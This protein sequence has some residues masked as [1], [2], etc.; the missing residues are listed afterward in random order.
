MKKRLSKKSFLKHIASGGHVPT[1]A[2]PIEQKSAFESPSGMRTHF[3]AMVRNL[4][5]E[6]QETRR[7]R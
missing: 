5:G 6:V 3:F 7:S 2:I 1:L 4:R